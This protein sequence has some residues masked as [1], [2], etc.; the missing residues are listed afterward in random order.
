MTLHPG[1]VGGR[2]LPQPTH[3]G[4]GDGGCGADSGGGI[5]GV[6]HDLK[7]LMGLQADQRGTGIPRR[8]KV[9]HR[10]VFGVKGY[11]RSWYRS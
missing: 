11:P 2:L 3:D 9:G 1:Q 6:V 7:R 4:A 10:V 8:V 5:E